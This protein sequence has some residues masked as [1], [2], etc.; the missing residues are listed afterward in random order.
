[1][2]D[3]VPAVRRIDTGRPDLQAFDI[4]GHV[5]T[6]DIENLFGLLEAA[7]ALHPRNDVLIRLIDIEGVDW[8]DADPETIKQG[9]ADAR[10]H[11]RRCAIV[12]EAGAILAAHG[13]LF[14]DAD[15]VEVRQFPPDEEDAAWAWLG[16]ETL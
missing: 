11:V 10:R 9:K 8:A 16:T 4:V 2:L 12:G 3:S 7:Y 15:P 6:S 14:L 1:M 13:A 5:S